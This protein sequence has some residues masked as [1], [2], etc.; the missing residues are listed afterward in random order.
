MN[1]LLSLL[2]L[3]CALAFSAQAQNGPLS[4][5][6]AKR[7]VFGSSLPAECDPGQG[8]QFFKTTAPVGIH[9]CAAANTWSKLSSGGLPDPGADGY[10]VRS[11]AATLARTFAV[12]SNLSVSNAN[13]T[14][15][16]TT[17][18]LGAN[19][20][21]AVTNDT[22]LQGSIATNTLT[23]I[24]TGTLAKARQH[25]A[26][27]YNDAANTWSA[28]A[29]DMGAAASFKLPTGAGAAPTASGLLAYDSTAHAVKAGANGV[30]RTL[31][32]ADGSGAALTNLDAAALATNSVPLA[33]ITEVLA[34]ADLTD[35]TGKQ[36]NATVV[37]MFGGGTPATNDCA[38]FDAN[39]NI[40]SAGGACTTG[41]GDNVTIN[42]AAMADVNFNDTTPAA[43]ANGFNVK[44]QRANGT[45]DTASAYLDPTIMHTVTWGNNTNNVVW[46]FD[47]PSGN[48]VLT[49]TDG[50]FDVSAGSLRVANIPVV[51]TSRTL[52]GGTGI[53]AI[54]DLS[55]DRTISFASTELN[56]LTWGDASLGSF[57]HTFN[58]S[59]GTDPVLTA[60]NNFLNLSTG[61]LQ[62]GGIQVATLSGPEELT[63]KTI[64]AEAAGNLITSVQKA[65]LVA[66]GCSNATASSGYDLATS[67]TPTA[68]CY[69]TSP[70]RFGG[71]DFA[72]GS[73]QNSVVN[74]PLP[75]DWTGSIDFSFVWF[76]GS[77][78]TNS[79]VW[80]LAT[81]CIANTEGL[82]APTYNAAQTVA[83]ANLATANTRNSASITTITTTGCAAGETMFL[84]IG[85]DPTN[86]SDTLAATA[87]LLGVEITLRRAQ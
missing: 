39:G 47:A 49:I 21:T 34:I 13:G 23:F 42:A 5:G 22:N 66:A 85:R 75:S 77:T 61:Q 70:Q 43:P 32:Y 14:G 86:G 26:T 31:L 55:A 51:V 78:S 4:G 64:N 71:L 27:V 56:A 48:S 62:Q 18:S 37:Q 24:W 65:Y 60:G 58:V 80:T 79:A 36:G 73:V 15:G 19:V 10:V 8:D 54:G 53:A 38:K 72:D 69:G 50:V 28:G 33:R 6:T 40:V 83:D 12:G 46:T 9:E 35:A 84:K 30:G 20:V 52:T 67:A 1:R 11:G 74:F 7:V 2:I 68:S 29:Q 57:A 41:A 63:N 87:V 59:T 81:A 17:I 44:W 45:P 82:L 16:N 3:L 76:S 25:A